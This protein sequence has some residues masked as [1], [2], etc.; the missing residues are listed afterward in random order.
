ML[1][2]S[3][4]N[5]WQKG[6]T[7]SQYNFN[8]IKSIRR[9]NG[10]HNKMPE[11]ACALVE[12]HHQWDVHSDQ[13]SETENRKLFAHVSHVVYRLRTQRLC[14]RVI[15][16]KPLCGK[17]ALWI[18]LDYTDVPATF[19]QGQNKQKLIWVLPKR[20]FESAVPSLVLICFQAVIIAATKCRERH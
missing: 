6:S 5:G 7:F 18:E 9:A 16:T 4:E 14:L 10:T 17:H 13:A 19:S 2:S 8:A 1:S 20:L 3:T 12:H 11:V 15:S